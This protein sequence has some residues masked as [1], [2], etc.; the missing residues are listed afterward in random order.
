MIIYN[1]EFLKGVDKKS[2]IYI[3]IKVGNLMRV[4]EIKLEFYKYLFF[5][6]N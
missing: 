4:R 3:V 1:V 2:I 6:N 5:D